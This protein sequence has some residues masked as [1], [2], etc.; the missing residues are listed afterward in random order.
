MS[1]SWPTGPRRPQLHRA[2]RDDGPPRPEAAADPGAGA[3]RDLLVPADAGRRPSAFA[4][5]DSEP[6]AGLS[7]KYGVTSEITAEGTINPDFSQV[8][9]DAFQVE[10]NQRFPLFFSEKRPF[11]MEGLGNFE[12]AG[13]GGDAIM[14]TAV[15]TRRIVD[16]FWGLKT[17]GSTGQVN[18]GVLAAGD[19]APGRQLVGEPNPFLGERK[20]F[21]IARGQYSLG[22]SSYVG[23]IVTDTE[24]ASGHNRVA[25]ADV[26]RRWGQ[27]SA[28]ATFLTTR[29]ES[30]D[31]AETS[32]GL[33]GQATYSFESKRFG[34]VDP[35]RALRPRLPDG[36]RVPEPGRHHPGL[37][38]RRAQLLPRRQE[39]PLVQARRA[40]RV[41]PVRAR[42]HPGRR[43]LDRGAGRAHAL[44]AAGLLPRRHHPRRGAV[45]AGRRSASSNTRVIARGPGHALAVL[46]R[47]RRRSAGRS[48]TTRSIPTSAS[49]AP[50]PS[51]SP[52]SRARASTRRSPTTAWSSTASTTASASSP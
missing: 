44:H 34:F 25:G 18:F 48:S 16:P 1:V 51:R 21:Y 45:P 29:T 23:A 31:G 17:T 28:S 27:Q 5:A 4:P 6:D 24:F 40:L 38:L 19:Q 46:L 11:F 22:R 52:C 8:E 20:D 43:S 2:P 36:H 49:A 9:S 26:S 3:Q 42:P 13:V 39:V 41:L 33:G 7:V 50:R 47:R 35:G 14:R 30:P 12:L 37:D 10:V 15:H 32:D